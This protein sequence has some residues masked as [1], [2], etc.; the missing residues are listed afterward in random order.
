MPFFSVIIPLYNKENQIEKTLNSVLN[1]TFDDFEIIIVNDGSTDNSLNIVNRFTDER[2]KIFSQENKGAASARNY[3]IKKAKAQYLALI[4]ADDFWFQDHLETHYNSIQSIPNGHLYSNAY[5]LKISRIKTINATYSTPKKNNPHIIDDYFKASIIHPIAMTSSIVFSYKKFN[6][7]GG[8]NEKITSGQDLDLMIRF[9]IDS[10]IVFNPKITCLYD[11]TVI[12][13]LSKQNYQ[14]IK[15][16]LFNGFK[17]E[18]KNNASLNKYL[19]LNL[20][21]LAIQCKLSNNVSLFKKIKKEINNNYLT[22]KQRF[23]LNQP[24]FLTKLF[25]RL[26][27]FLINNNIYLTAYR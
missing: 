22:K 3:G 10:T 18:K 8:Y 21:S 12:N 13:S 23:L 11:K 4:D 15:Y 26:H 7:L 1:Q 2:I 5:K 27:R 14:K 6:S 25:K 20:Y 19:N 24:I 9:G 17:N 16:N